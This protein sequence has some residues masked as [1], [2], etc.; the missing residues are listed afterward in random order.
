MLQWSNSQDAGALNTVNVLGH[1][2]LGYT[3]IMGFEGYYVLAVVFLIRV[4]LEF[5]RTGGWNWMGLIM[6]V[7]GWVIGYLLVKL[8][9]KLAVGKLKQYLGEVLAN[10]ERS[11]VRNVLTGV[12]IAVLAVWMVKSSGNM[13]GIGVV[14]GIAVRLYA[15]ML[16]DRNQKRWYWI[17][18]REFSGKEQK[19]IKIVWGVI[20]GLALL[21]LV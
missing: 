15:D 18:A 2:F 6:L 19:I 8:E 21:G 17:F 9:R 3:G 4:T 14:T 5:M 13:L 11:P 16:N 1:L 20:V 7:A 12:V 10:C